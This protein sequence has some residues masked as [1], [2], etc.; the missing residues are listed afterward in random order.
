MGTKHLYVFGAV[1]VL[2]IVLIVA[3]EKKG[4]NKVLPAKWQKQSFVGSMAR[5]PEMQN[6]LAFSGDGDR[7]AYF[8]RCT[9]V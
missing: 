6:C 5:T 4:L 9:W 7:S 8:N 3:Y 1:V 2:V